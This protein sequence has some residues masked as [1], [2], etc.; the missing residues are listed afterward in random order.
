M[1]TLG[2]DRMMLYLCIVFYTSILLL[3]HDEPQLSTCPYFKILLFLR[4]VLSWEGGSALLTQPERI[5]L[6]N[7]END[8]YLQTAFMFFLFINLTLSKISCF[9]VTTS[10]VSQVKFETYPIHWRYLRKRQ[11]IPIASSWV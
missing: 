6:L 1:F 2:L 10:G 7:K 4:G 9:G 5:I 3:F 8:L 11:A